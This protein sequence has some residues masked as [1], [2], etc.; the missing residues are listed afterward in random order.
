MSEK[1][2]WGW[3]GGVL[4]SGQYSRIESGETA[5]GFP[6]VH[7]QLRGGRSGTLELKFARRFRALVPFK[8]EEDGLHKSQLIWI[9]DNLRCDGKVFIVAEITPEVLVIPGTSA[10]AF[11]GSTLPQLRE[12]AIHRLSRE[13]PEEAAYWFDLLLRD[14]PL[15]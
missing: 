7:Y 6:D 1:T 12:L 9:R 5:P 15:A 2:L 14:V 3:L 8:N 10:S 13:K 4:P 11:N